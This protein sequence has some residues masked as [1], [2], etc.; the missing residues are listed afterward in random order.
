MYT[1]YRLPRYLVVHHN[2][3]LYMKIEIPSSLPA[4]QMSCRRKEVSLADLRHS[5][6]ACRLVNLMNLLDAVYKL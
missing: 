1:G 3:S 2:I 5:P 4:S 6:I